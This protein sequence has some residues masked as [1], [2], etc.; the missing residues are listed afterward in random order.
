MYDPHPDEVKK[1]M[2]KKGKKAINH[3]SF[4]I[5]APTRTHGRSFLSILAKESKLLIAFL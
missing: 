1:K 5:E 3:F 2:K 4:S